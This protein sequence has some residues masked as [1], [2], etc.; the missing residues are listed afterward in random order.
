MKYLITPYAIAQ[1][2]TAVLSIIV[3]SIIWMRRS[4]RGGWLLFLLF[5]AISIWALADGFEAAATEQ[6]T[7]ILWS[8]IGYFGAHT[9]PV[10]LFL[11]SLRYTG[12][13]RKIS[14]L[15]TCLLF[16]EPA[17]IIF[18]AATNETH[19]LIWSSFS[20]GPAGSNS[21]IYN[22]GPAFWVGIAYIF[23][24]ISFATAFFIIS[25]VRTQR[26]Y[27]LQ[28]FILLAATLFPWI[29]SLIYIFNLNPFPGLDTV[30]ISF[31]FS[32][33]LLLIGFTRSSLMDVVPV[34]NDLIIENI[35]DGI[36][37]I[38]N[39]YRVIDL[40]P[41]AQQL[42]NLKFNQVFGASLLNEFELWQ[43]IEKHFT[44]DGSSHFEIESPRVSDTWLGVSVSP[45]RDRQSTFLGWAIIFEDITQRKITEKELQLAHNR[46]ERRLKEI[47]S[48]Q[49][50]LQEQAIRDSL[51]GV[52]NRGYLEET[53]G[54][55][56]AH[57]ER[58]GYS[59]SV[60]MLDVDNFKTINDSFGHK[61]GDDVVVA[62]GRL[63]Q[64]QT[65]EG[66]CVSRY[67]GDEFVLV[68]PEMTREDAYQRAEIWRNGLKAMIFQQKEG[69]IHVT[70]SIG[71]ATFPKNGKN[72]DALLNAVDQALYNAKHAGRDC[73]RLAD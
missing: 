29:G 63:L 19:G 66:D 65:R 30:C 5:T 60:I 7:K 46:L 70:V 41:A 33:L 23:S 37:I 50:K 4:A 25:A 16:I 43:S 53:L 15:T 69:I 2:V 44:Q 8:K 64:S 11:F 40:N 71:I 22:H 51:T 17:L 58:K 42:L 21:L 68:M 62:L 38:D 13:N 57:A 20:P 48:L 56:I 55:E 14:P 10:F 73:T 27:K 67:G 3:A 47:R 6:A 1:F 52:F 39:Q 28:S 45:L 72:S 18:L 31:F 36:L 35:D 9:S 59:L 24:M 26:V 61:T 12:K 34:A 32:G 54:R 49:D